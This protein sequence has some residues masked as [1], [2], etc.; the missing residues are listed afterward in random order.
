MLNSVPTQRSRTRSSGMDVCGASIHERIGAAHEGKVPRPQ[1]LNLALVLQLPRPIKAHSSSELHVRR[2]LGGSLLKS[3]EGSN[4]IVDSLVAPR[5]TL[6]SAWLAPWRNQRTTAG[7]RA[8]G[9]TEGVRG[10]S[11]QPA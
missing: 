6:T 4:A 11:V 5:H 2:H 10:A 8:K 9:V 3:F 1:P 7:R